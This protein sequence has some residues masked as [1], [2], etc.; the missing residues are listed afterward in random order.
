MV[1][2]KQKVFRVLKKKQNLTT[3]KVVFIHLYFL[4]V[5]SILI[6]TKEDSNNFYISYIIKNAIDVHIQN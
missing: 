1:F 4:I 6:K 2:Y 3:I 5:K